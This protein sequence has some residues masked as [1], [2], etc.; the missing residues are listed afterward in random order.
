MFYTAMYQ[1]KINSP[2]TPSVFITPPGWTWLYVIQPR[3]R[4]NDGMDGSCFRTPCQQTTIYSRTFP[5][6]FLATFG[7]PKFEIVRCV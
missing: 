1:L 3:V 4:S 7:E 5:G 6:L 2:D